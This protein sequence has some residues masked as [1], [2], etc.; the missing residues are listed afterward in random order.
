MIGRD[1]GRQIDRLFHGRTEVFA[2]LTPRDMLA[3]MPGRCRRTCRVM[4]PNVLASERRG[5][6]KLKNVVAVSF[7]LGDIKTD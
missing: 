5:F 4:F 1:K 3:R 7:R 2:L 6:F